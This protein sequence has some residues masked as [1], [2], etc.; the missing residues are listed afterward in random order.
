M[1]RTVYTEYKKGDGVQYSHRVQIYAAADGRIQ[2][3]KP[4]DLTTF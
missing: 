1:Q 4:V 2:L 3:L